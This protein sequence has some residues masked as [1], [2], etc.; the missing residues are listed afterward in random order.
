MKKK[1]FVNIW[2]CITYELNSKPS[3]KACY[4]CTNFSRFRKNVSGCFTILVFVMGTL[5]K[6]VVYR[7]FKK[8]QKILDR[9]INVL[10]LLD[11]VLHHILSSLFIYFHLYRVFAGEL[12]SEELE[13]SFPYQNKTNWWYFTIIFLQLPTPPFCVN[14]CL[15]FFVFL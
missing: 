5:M 7:Y 11:Q 14:L 15:Q 8:M 9:P 13:S 4:Y 2:H 1:S 12:F 6:M 10:I 3:K